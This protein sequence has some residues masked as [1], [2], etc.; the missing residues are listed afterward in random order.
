MGQSGFVGL[1]TR[2]GLERGCVRSSVWPP[3][4][5]GLMS[6][7]PT[8]MLHSFP[9]TQRGLLRLS[10]ASCPPPNPSQTGWLYEPQKRMT[11][12]S[13]LLSLHV[14]Q[15]GWEDCY[16]VTSFSHIALFQ[17]LAHS[18]SN[19]SE[20]MMALFLRCTLGFLTLF[21]PSLAESEALKG[22][23]ALTRAIL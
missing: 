2:K 17:P 16:L 14:P 22:T 21:S 10:S 4:H 15:H 1:G 23:M 19:G 20:G 11:P 5:S 3:Q 12:C 18:Q 9:W 7:W 6:R 13:P 8:P